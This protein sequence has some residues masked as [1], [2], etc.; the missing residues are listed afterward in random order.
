ME[1]GVDESLCVD[2]S[3]LAEESNLAINLWKHLSRKQRNLV[4]AT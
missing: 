3:R 2:W 1:N 4:G